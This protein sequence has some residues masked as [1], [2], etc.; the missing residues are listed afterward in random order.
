MTAR[1]GNGAAG[2][3]HKVLLSVRVAAIAAR[4]HVVE[5]G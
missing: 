5:G 4:R 1:T 3:P 2:G